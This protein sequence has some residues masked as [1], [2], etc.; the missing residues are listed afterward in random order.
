MDTDELLEKHA[1]GQR[2]FRWATIHG[3]HLAEACLAH[4][5]LSRADLVTSN[6]ACAD[7]S[8]A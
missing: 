6:L 7:L 5:C 1:A 4:A 3:A 2:D 8:R